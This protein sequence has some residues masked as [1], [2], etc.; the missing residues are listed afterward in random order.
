MK[1]EKQVFVFIDKNVYSEFKTYLENKGN[2]KIKY[3]YVDNIKIYEFIEN[4]EGLAKNNP[5]QTFESSEEIIHFLKEQWA[6]LFQ[7]FLQEQKRIKEVNLL[8][9]LANT[10]TTLNQLINYLT[11]EK[12]GTEDTI[13]DI[14][15]SNHPAFERL[16]A[17]LVVPYRIFFLTKAELSSWLN[18][19]SYEE[20]NELL[21]EDEDVAEWINNT[22]AN[23]EQI[24]KINK[25]IFDEDGNLKPIKQSAWAS[26]FIRIEL[27]DTQELIKVDDLP[28]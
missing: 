18:A 13:R 9:G 7:R 14:L 11:E 20:V 10:A 4:L 22:R 23:K 28:F 12:K 1:L 27:K 2:T 16:K 21:W 26:D 3:H 24:L 6:G 19:R 5:I 8:Q 15:I 25:N 17:L